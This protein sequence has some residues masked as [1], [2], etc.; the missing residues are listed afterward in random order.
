ML[1]PEHPEFY[2]F[3]IKSLASLKFTG[4]NFFLPDFSH[5]IPENW[6]IF[7]DRIDD[8][9]FILN[10]SATGTSPRYGLPPDG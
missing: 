7:H 8:E 2:I 4:R 1:R 10:L 6:G 5:Q 9:I 3:E